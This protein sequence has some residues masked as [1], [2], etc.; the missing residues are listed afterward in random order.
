MVTHSKPTKY[1]PLHQSLWVR[2]VVTKALL[3]STKQTERL[4][5]ASSGRDNFEKESQ[6][7][8]DDS[9]KPQTFWALSHSTEFLFLFLWVH[10][11]GT[12][13]LGGL[14]IGVFI[15][16]ERDLWCSSEIAERKEPTLTFYI[17]LFTWWQ[18]IL[19]AC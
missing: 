19:L 11:H 17:V 1:Q 16:P 6:R 4:W 8:R 5:W 12:Y 2:S 14:C 18:S 7:E 3:T 9:D 13:C 10:L 15:Q